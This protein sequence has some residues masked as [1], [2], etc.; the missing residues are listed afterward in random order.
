MRTEISSYMITIYLESRKEEEALLKWKA[1]LRKRGV[2]YSDPEGIQIRHM[3]QPKDGWTLE[4]LR[5]A[6][7]DPSDSDSS[8]LHIS[9][10]LDEIIAQPPPIKPKEEPAWEWT[11]EDVKNAFAALTKDTG[12]FDLSKVADHLAAIRTSLKVGDVVRLKSGG[13]EMTVTAFVEKDNE[14]QCEWHIRDEKRIWQE[15]KSW[16]FPLEAL[17]I[18]KS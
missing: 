17:K 10:M 9:R 15:V 5:T 8:T 18:E 14:F 4:D 3:Y 2:Q 7:G 11:A 12:S 1:G 6:L 13:P 16:G